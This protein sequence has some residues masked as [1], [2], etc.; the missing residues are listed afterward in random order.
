MILKNLDKIANKIRI[1]IIQEITSAGSGH[2]GGSL[3]IVEI[4]CS[5]YFG[6]V[7]NFDSKNPHDPKRDRFIMSKAH[8]CPALYAVFYELGLIKRAELL[9]LRKFGSRLQGHPDR[10][11]FDLIETS[12]GSL[13]QGLSIACG[14]AL[15]AKLD[16]LKYKTFVLMSD[17]EQ[18][19]GQI[20]E[21]VMTAA[22]YNLDNLIGIV[23]INGL[24]IDGCTEHVKSLDL[25]K[26]K[27]ECFDWHA[28]EVDGHNI[29]ALIDAFHEAEHIH[30]KPIIILAH[31]VKGKGVS[32][33]ENECAWHGKA[34]NKQEAEKAIAEL[35]K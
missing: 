17:G 30:N 10:Q 9:T 4:L 32:F 6:G 25:L 5:L 12:G 7:L 27:Y 22:H 15:S 29:Q 8:C 1:D 18:E 21:A 31:T 20:W 24:Q 13:G 3:S 2:P 33:M 35:K 16:G 28:I 34:P 11:K 19:E 26:E 14:M 23:D